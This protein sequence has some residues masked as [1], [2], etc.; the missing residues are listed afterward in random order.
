MEVLLAVGMIAPDFIGVTDEGKQIKL[1]D[2][3]G[4]YVVLY[5]YPKDDTPGCTKQACNF[6]DNMS[7]IASNDVVVIGVSTDSVESHK[8]FKQKYNLNFILVSDQKKEIS[9]KY[10]VL[11][12]RGTSNRQTFLIDDKGIIRYIWTTVNVNTH[13]K[14]V[15]AK[16]KEIKSKDLQN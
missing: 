8:K 1:S 11:N 5:F 14:D 4:K 15:I 2:Y 7:E 16:V 12:F 9:S 6:R 13:A 10:G 3:R